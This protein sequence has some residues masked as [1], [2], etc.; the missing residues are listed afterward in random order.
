MEGKINGG[1]PLLRL[2]TTNGNITIEKAAARG[3]SMPP[4][5]LSSRPSD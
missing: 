2:R 3:A 4:A 5:S 1:G